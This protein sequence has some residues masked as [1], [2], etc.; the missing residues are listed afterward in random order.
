MMLPC[1]DTAEVCGQTRSIKYVRLERN[2][3]VA[4]ARN[5]G[6][7]L[8]RPSSLPFNDDEICGLP[9]R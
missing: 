5:V 2:Q 1:D 4:A 3:G 7:I 6:I 9:V 8:A